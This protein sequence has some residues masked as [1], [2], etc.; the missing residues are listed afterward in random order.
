[1]PKHIPLTRGLSAL[2][3][4][5]DY[6]WLSRWKWL[7]VG[8]GYAGRF[9]GSSA[10]RHL[11]Y[12]HRAVVGAQPGQRVDHINQDRLDNRREN[13]R[14][15]TNAQNQQNKKRPSHNQ[16]GYKGVCWHKGVGKWHARIVVNGQRVHLGYYRDLETAALLYDAAARY[17]FGEY[18]CPNFPDTPTSPQTAGLLAHV[19]ARRAA[20][21]PLPPAAS[22]CPNET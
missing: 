21:F 4:D 14:L 20:S 7:V 13:L 10:T 19:L 11:V 12:M 16:S 22:S 18:A 8:P 6:D 5:A 3:S 17:F 1:M 2:V 9:E 15:V